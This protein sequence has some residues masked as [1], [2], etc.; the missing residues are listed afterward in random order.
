MLVTPGDPGK[1]TTETQEET[2][3]EEDT[4]EESTTEESTETENSTETETADSETTPEEKKGE[5]LLFHDPKDIPKELLPIFK[6]MQGS[7]TRKMQSLSGVARKA[8]AFDELSRMPQFQ[9]FLENNGIV[10]KTT[11]AKTKED[12][13]DSDVLDAKMEE[14]LEPIRQK[15]SKQELDEEFKA[16]ETKYPFY[17]NFKPLMR[18]HLDSNPHHTFEQALAIVAFPE[19]LRL[20]GNKVST[21]SS[22]KKKANITKPN[23]G[24]SA[25][26]KNVQKAKSIE[27]AWAL[28]KKQ[29]GLG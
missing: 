14:K 5:E 3:T 18:E 8:Q 7:F 22:T 28:S 13:N 11:P 21:V 16:F 10:R 24:S 23:Q 6:K 20:L 1:E 9:E 4:Q 17:E 12:G 27:E 29:L 19:L 2:T 15:L 26:G 25:T